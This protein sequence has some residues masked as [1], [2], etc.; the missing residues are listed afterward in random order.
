MRELAMWILKSCG[1]ERQIILQVQSIMNSLDDTLPK[2]E[3]LAKLRA[4][5]SAC[6]RS[7][8]EPEGGPVEG[9]IRLNA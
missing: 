2:E 8:T 6:V 9:T 7:A 5:R 1:G 3:A 4:L